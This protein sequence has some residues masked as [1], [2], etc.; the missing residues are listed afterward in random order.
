MCFLDLVLKITC[1]TTRTLGE[2]FPSFKHRKSL[3]DPHDILK[4]TWTMA[5]GTDFHAWD[6]ATHEKTPVIID[7]CAFARS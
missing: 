1:Q 6:F 3:V 4:K 7:I 2:E 5:Y